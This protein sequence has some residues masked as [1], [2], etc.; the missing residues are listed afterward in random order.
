[1]KQL[2]ALFLRNPRSFGFIVSVL[3]FLFTLSL[4]TNQ[5]VYAATS[6]G[7]VTM[8]LS[9]ATSTITP[10][11]ATSVDVVVNTGTTNVIGFQVQA[12]ITGTIPTDLV[13]TPKPPSNATVTFATSYNQLSTITG[14]RRLQ[15]ILD[16]S[17]A[18]GYSTANQ[19]VVIG[20][21]TFTAPTTGAMTITFDQSQSLIL[22]DAYVDVLR[23]VGGAVYTFTAPIVPTNT[24]T[25]TPTTRPTNTPTTRPTNTP[26]ARPTNTPTTRPTNTPTIRVTNT[27][28]NT[29]TIKPTNTPTIRPSSTIS[30]ATPTPTL[31]PVITAIVPSPTPP[32]ATDVQLQPQDSVEVQCAGAELTLVQMP[33]GTYIATCNAVAVP[34]PMP[35]NDTCAGQPTGSSCTYNICPV[36]NLGVLCPL[37]ALFSPCTQ[38]GGICQYGTCVANAKPT[39][40]PGCSYAPGIC[41]NLNGSV[42]PERLVCVSPTVA[43]TRPTPTSTTK[44]TPTPAATTGFPRPTR[45]AFPTR[46][47]TGTIPYPTTKPIGGNP[48]CFN[49]DLDLNEDGKVSVLDLS[50]II[51]NYN[52][53]GTVD[54]PL[55]ADVNCD[56]TVNNQDFSAWTRRRFLIDWLNRR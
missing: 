10:G 28:T 4:H 14:G 15:V 27:P 54:M 46:I 41:T 21:F 19:N 11:S 47:P 38:Q 17:S 49:G 48:I 39:P 56:G 25:N 29:P 6:S 52:K 51:A 55:R 40:P 3:A 50:L 26:T 22:S 7:T 1:M 23:T 37:T 42:C 5:L 24:P 12:D 31:S 36:C 34:T 32:L 35:S 20:T 9:K 44:I 33:D 18:A 30:P 45:V 16:T 53:R 13:F 2:L 43:S 8:Q